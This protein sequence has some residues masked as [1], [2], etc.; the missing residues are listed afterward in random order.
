MFESVL[1]CPLS[2]EKIKEFRI[3]TLVVPNWPIHGQSME[4]VV[5]EVCETV[6]GD[7]ARDGFKRAGVANRQIMPKNNTKKNLTRIAGN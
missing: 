1:T 6:Y 5:K 4:R 7:K 2:L 3:T